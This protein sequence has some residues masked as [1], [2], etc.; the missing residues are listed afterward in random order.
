MSFDLDIAGFVNRTIAEQHRITKVIIFSLDRKIMKK[1]PVGDPDSWQR[2]ELAPPGYTG[3]R[4]RVNWQLGVNTIP[5][6]EIEGIDKTG[7]STLAK[8]AAQI[9]RLAGGHVYYLVNNVPYAQ[10]LED[11]HSS[12]SEP[13]NMVAGTVAE[14]RGIIMRAVRG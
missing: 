14:F 6:G 10:A 8:H 1:S 4:F 12:Q 7:E 11:G 2:P 5:G 13:G 9:P 3:G